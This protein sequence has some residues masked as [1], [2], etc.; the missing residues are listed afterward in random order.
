M[1]TAQSRV[2][3]IKR[4]LQEL[5]AINS[6]AQKDLNTVAG[7]ERVKKW[8][9]KTVPLFSAELGPEAAQRLAATTPG[10]SFTSDLLEELSDEIEVYRNCL[11]QLLDE[12][13]K[14]SDG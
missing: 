11:L 13:K 5:D 8:K 2:E 3:L 10:P 12:I 6:Q 1:Q 7:V 14:S 4:Q 9:A